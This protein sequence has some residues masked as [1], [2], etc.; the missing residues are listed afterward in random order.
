MSFYQRQLNKNKID[1]EQQTIKINQ[2][3]S[4]MQTDISTIQQHN[5][6]PIVYVCM[7]NRRFLIIF[8]KL[9]F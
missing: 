5:S 4:Q 7:K 3:D 8:S 9:L 2:H 6:K 1:R